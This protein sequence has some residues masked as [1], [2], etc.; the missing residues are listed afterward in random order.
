MI[1]RSVRPQQFIIG[2]DETK[3]KLS[4][5]SKSFLKMV[6]D[7]VRERQ[8]RS[9]MNVT[10]NEEKH[11]MIW[12][13]FMSVAL[14]SA[15]FMGIN[16]LDNRHSITN[17]KLKDLTLKQVFDISARLVSEQ[18]EIS[19]L[20][21]INMEHLQNMFMIGDESLINLQRTKIY[22]FSDSVL[23]LG[24]INENI[25]SNDAWEERW[26]WFKFCLVHRNFDRIDGE[27]V[28]FEWSIFPGFNTVQLSEEVKSLLLS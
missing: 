1:P 3:S 28:E 4:V 8:K 12:K 26:G 16:D 15:V 22:V 21:T 17:L 2:N 11:F 18:Y 6:N 13:I 25:Q 23:C 10:E 14:E 9:S 27:S 5:E 20:D 24:K 19:E 7:H